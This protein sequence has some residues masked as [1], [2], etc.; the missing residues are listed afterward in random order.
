MDG[1]RAA[2][3]RLAPQPLGDADG[4]ADRGLG[5]LAAQRCH[6]GPVTGEIFDVGQAVGVEGMS[7]LGRRVAQA[8]RR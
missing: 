2:K 5:G 4:F 7:Q 6:Q 3:Q 1:F 8:A